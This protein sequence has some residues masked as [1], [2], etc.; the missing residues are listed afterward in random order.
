MPMNRPSNPAWR[1]LIVGDRPPHALILYTSRLLVYQR[2]NSVQ[3]NP[4][5][6]FVIVW[7]HCAV[8]LRPL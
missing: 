7:R 3:L 8:T 5:S 1:L 6:L 2:L 4:F